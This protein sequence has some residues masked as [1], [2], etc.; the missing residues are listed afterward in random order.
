[1]LDPGGGVELYK[2]VSDPGWV[3]VVVVFI[4]YLLDSFHSADKKIRRRYATKKEESSKEESS[5]TQK[6][7]A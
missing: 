3:W 5:E 2:A 4:L 1:M 6:G 7:H